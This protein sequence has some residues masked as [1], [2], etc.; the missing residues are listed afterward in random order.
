M[1]IAKKP[2]KANGKTYK[3]G[4]EA[5]FHPVWL[6]AGLIEEGTPKKAKKE[7]KPHKVKK[8]IK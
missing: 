5:P 3:H 1:Y 8:E 7:T 2:F 4:D 6:D